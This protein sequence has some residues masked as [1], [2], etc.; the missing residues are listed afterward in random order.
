MENCV[1]PLRIERVLG[2]QTPQR[3]GGP[4]AKRQPSPEGWVGIPITIQP[5]PAR[6]GSA[7]GAARVRS[8][9]LTSLEEAKHP[10]TSVVRAPFSCNDADLSITTT[11]RH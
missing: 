7:I 11:C 1:R 9:E 2:D 4:P 6:R 5:A 8:L 10:V 3:P